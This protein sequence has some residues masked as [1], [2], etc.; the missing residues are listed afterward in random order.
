MIYLQTHFNKQ[1]VAQ[2]SLVLPALLQLVSE[3]PAQVQHGVPVDHRALNLIQGDNGRVPRLVVQE[4][5]FSE[6]AASVQ[7]GH[8]ALV[9]DDLNVPLLYEEEQ[10][11][12]FSLLNNN[13]V[14]LS[15]VG[16]H[17]LGEHVDLL[18][19]QLL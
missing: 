18:F 4:R 8:L 7:L 11:S 12:R 2:T 16:P 5:L 3:P 9:V 19:L 13:S 15:N 6:V 10:V 17:R 14:R 1:R